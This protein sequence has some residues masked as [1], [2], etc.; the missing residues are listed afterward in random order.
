MCLLADILKLM[1]SVILVKLAALPTEDG[2][3]DR[4]S[5]D[6]SPFWCIEL[7]VSAHA[8]TDHVGK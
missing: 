5:I 2:D 4:V 8:G 3:G 7:I 1:A 6:C